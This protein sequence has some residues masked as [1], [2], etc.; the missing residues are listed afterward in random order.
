MIWSSLLKNPLEELIREGNV[1][2]PSVADAQ[3]CPISCHLH[4]LPFRAD[5]VKEHHE[6]QLE[7]HDRINGGASSMCVGVLS[8]CT[9]EREVGHALEASI[10][11]ALWYQ[12][13]K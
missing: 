12:L 11:M 6:L 1:S 2:P 10:E 8:Q 7:E 9:H 13:L 3:P 4:Q 5:A